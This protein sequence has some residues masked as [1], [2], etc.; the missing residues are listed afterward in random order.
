MDNTT[1]E[2]LQILLA[3]YK[4]DDTARIN[5]NTNTN[6]NRGDE[7]ECLKQIIDRQRKK[8]QEYETLYQDMSITYNEKIDRL[9]EDH[10]QEITKIHSQF[11]E[12]LKREMKEKNHIV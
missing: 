4:Y 9:R 5:T 3:K 2:E 1:N 8:I 10:A 11:R 12:R 6:T 7:I